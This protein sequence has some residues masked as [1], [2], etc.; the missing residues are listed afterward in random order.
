MQPTVSAKLGVDIYYDGQIYTAYCEALELS[1]Y[2]DSL[3]DA[4]RAFEDAV[5]I[6]I[7]ETDKA[8]TLE[9]ELVKLGWKLQS[10]PEPVY[11]L[12]R[13]KASRKHAENRI[14]IPVTFPV[15]TYATNIQ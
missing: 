6:F 4:Q 13:L 7:T 9:R 11:K 3:E 1:T 15:P 14:M 5:H 8:G 12:P 10:L 2:G